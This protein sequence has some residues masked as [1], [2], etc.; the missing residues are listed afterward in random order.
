MGRPAK[1]MNRK[2][3]IQ[4]DLSEP[5]SVPIQGTK[6]KAQGE[7]VAD[8]ETLP[9]PDAP[10]PPDAQTQPPDAAGPAP[11]QEGDTVSFVQLNGKVRPAK[12]L[13][14]SELGLTLEMLTNGHVWRDVLPGKNPG[15]WFKE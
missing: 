15:H 5:T 10:P 11:V 1:A 8:P 12:V 9:P 14:V 3:P 4:P 6:D 2:L 7:A 13:S